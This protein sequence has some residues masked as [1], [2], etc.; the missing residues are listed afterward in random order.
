MSKK[1]KNAEQISAIRDVVSKTLG[2]TPTDDVIAQVIEGKPLSLDSLMERHTP[3]E[4][5]TALIRLEALSK[6]SPRNEE[7]A[8][9]VCIGRFCWD[10]EP[11]NPQSDRGIELPNPQPDR[12]TDVVR[13]EFGE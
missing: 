9:R 10:I 11:P 7:L 5:G 2:L 13:K 1:E 3:T 12:G 4:I 6:M 8:V